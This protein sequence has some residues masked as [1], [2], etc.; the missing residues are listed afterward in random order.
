M[1]D[2]ETLGTKPNARILQI[3]AVAFEAQPRGRIH[4]DKA[5]SAYIKEDERGTV[6]ISTFKWWLGQSA[7]ARGRMIDGLTHKAQA[8]RLALLEL[9]TNW[10]KKLGIE[11]W[12]EFEGIWS[13][14]AS[15]DVPLL[16]SAYARNGQNPPWFYSAV[17]DTRTLFMLAGGAPQVDTTGMVA[18]DAVD[19][20]VA[21]CMQ[22]TKALSILAGQP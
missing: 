15:F 11:S 22:V 17:R 3:A 8:E 21:Q 14:G 10:P 5:F 4:N 18:H 20:C 16:A 2:L 7:E 1:I 9:S 12:R 13:H 19:D 6:D